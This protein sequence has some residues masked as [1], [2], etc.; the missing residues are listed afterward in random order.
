MKYRVASASIATRYGVDCAPWRC[1]RS[2]SAAIA[3]SV[4]DSRRLSSPL[5]N[6]ISQWRWVC[7][8]MAARSGRRTGFMSAVQ[9]RRKCDMSVKVS[10]VTSLALASALTAASGRGCAARCGAELQG[11]ML[12]R[13]P[14]GPERLRRRRRH[15]LCRNVQG[16]LPGQ[17]L[18]SGAE[19]HLHHYRNAV[20]AG[21]ALA[22][23]AP[24]V[25]RYHPAGV[26][27]ASTG[28]AYTAWCRPHFPKF[29]QVCPRPFHQCNA[30]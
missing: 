16:R 17:R 13:C 7:R 15:H 26:I 24:G 9:D 25:I 1:R 4:P 14:Q 2:L 27:R 3:A 10:T 23:Q 12:R 11:E 19:G 5:S 30:Q 6:S 22:D 20:R 29:V 8:F 28:S 18:E 21:F